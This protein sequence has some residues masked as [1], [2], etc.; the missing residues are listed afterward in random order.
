MAGGG[1]DEKTNTDYI[2]IFRSEYENRVRVLKTF[3]YLVEILKDNKTTMNLRTG[4]SD[5]LFTAAAIKRISP[6]Q[7]RHYNYQVWDGTTWLNC[8]CRITVKMRAHILP[9]KKPVASVPLCEIHYTVDVTFSAE[10]GDLFTRCTHNHV[11]EQD[12]LPNNG[13]L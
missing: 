4:V 2:M 13:T 6:I 11:Y 3:T 7:V 5:I 9:N 12:L 8:V 1:C 10:N